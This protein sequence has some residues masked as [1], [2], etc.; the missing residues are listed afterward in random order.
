MTE[1][2][3]DMLTGGQAMARQLAAEGVEHIFG[4]PGVQL[5]YASNGLSAHTD[6]IRFINVRHE[7]TATYAAD[8]YA[9]STG[10]IGVGLV[11]PGPGV[12]NAGSGLVTA[13]ACS[14]PVLLISGQIPSRGIGRNLGLLHEIPDQSGILSTLCRHSTLVAEPGEVAGAIHGAM[15]R[16]A[17][18][19]GPVAV[20]LPPDVLYGRTDGAAIGP[21][22]AGTPS[23]GTEAELGLVAER[24]SAAERPVILAGGGARVA[25]AAW[26]A[27]PALAQATGAALVGTTN[28]KGAFDDR[29]PYAFMPLAAKELLKRADVVLCVGSRGLD[30]R[31]NPVAVGADTVVLSVNH[32]AA[33]FDPPRDYAATV[34]GDAGTG[35]AALAAMIGGEKPLWLDDADEVRARWEAEITGLEPQLSFARALREAMPDDAVLVNELTQVGY[36]ARYDYDVRAP[37]SYLD[38]GYQGTLGYGYPTAVGAVV[39]NP[40]RAVVSVNGDGGFGYGLAELATVANHE[41]PLVGVV[42]TDS[43]YGNV[44][45]MHKQQFDG[46]FHGTALKNPDFVALAESFDVRGMRATTPEEFRS[47]LSSAIDSRK[48]ALIEVPIGEVPDPW[49]LV[50]RPWD[51]P[52]N[53]VGE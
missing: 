9:R 12:L 48:A 35:A 10:R 53:G 30:T 24:L 5:D 23:P 44:Q 37:N 46:V 13:L 4:I 42:F 14:S 51:P 40:H 15:V 34:L 26:E 19:P 6:Q 28:G 31:G 49:S 43:A 16:L 29:N 7:Q 3:S 8:G 18:G 1:T 32:D 17:N 41:L 38:P 39:G 22:P 25:G 45:R 21:E 50:M 20:E 52:A 27:L 2:T 33:A 36:A 11:V 47:T